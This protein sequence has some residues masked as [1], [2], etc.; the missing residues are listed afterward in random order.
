MKRAGAR[1]VLK[2]SGQLLPSTLFSIFAD[3]G[4]PSA[5]LAEKRLSH[6]GGFL[7]PSMQPVTKKI[8]GPFGPGI[9]HP[10]CFGLA[11]VTLQQA[12][13]SLAVTAA[14]HGT[15]PTGAPHAT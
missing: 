6:P 9:L 3:M 4:F 5:S 15:S 2:K 12:L 8:P 14:P 10:Y 13:E 11:E 1:P 7:P